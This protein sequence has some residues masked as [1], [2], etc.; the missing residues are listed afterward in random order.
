MKEKKRKGANGNKKTLKLQ[1]GKDDT[2]KME[3]GTMIERESACNVRA[4]DS[5]NKRRGSRHFHDKLCYV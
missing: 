2:C 4:R 3:E 5:Q 1:L